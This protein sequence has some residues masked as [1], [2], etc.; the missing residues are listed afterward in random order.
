MP[1]RIVFT[2]NDKS[3]ISRAIMWF[4]QHS[5]NK[6]TRCSHVLFKYK[7]CGIAGEQWWAYEAMERGC[8]PSP[9]TK[10][11]GKQTIVAEFELKV[12]DSLNRTML[13]EL[14]DETCG[15]WY[16]FEGIWRW[17]WWI[18]AERFFGTIVSLLKLTFRPGKSSEGA[19][20]SGLVLMGIQKYQ[21]ALPEYDFGMAKLT[22]RTSSP[23]N[24][25]DI[26][27]QHP[28]IY[29]GGLGP[30]DDGLEG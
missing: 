5:R 9:W 23:Q 28:D 14:F 18:I 16:D 2:R 7:P 29:K 20:C 11:L 12:P 4:T 22:P 10:S 21:A 30:L 25:V 8:W 1:V 27:I 26:C 6:E 3:F 13:N 24:E 17:A 15:E 19:F